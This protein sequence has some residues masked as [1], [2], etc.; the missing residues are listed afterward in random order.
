LTVAAAVGDDAPVQRVCTGSPVPIAPTGRV[1]VA[2]RVRAARLLAG[3][4]SLRQVAAD[5]GMSYMH[6]SAVKR[7]RD[8]L[9]PSDVSDLSRVLGCPP[10]FLERGWS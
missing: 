5:T 6:L 4:P 1:A 9:L 7:G 2:R 10:W 8:P 3:D